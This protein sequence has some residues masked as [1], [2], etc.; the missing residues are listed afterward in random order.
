MLWNS[1]VRYVTMSKQQ[2]KILLWA[3]MLLFGAGRE[4]LRKTIIML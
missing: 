3:K 1:G 4:E 2:G